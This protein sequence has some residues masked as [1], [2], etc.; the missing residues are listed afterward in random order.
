[1]ART[2]STPALD[3][4]VDALLAAAEHAAHAETMA[5]AR[6]FELAAAWAEAHPA[7]VTEDVV[8]ELGELAMYAD[9]PVTLAGEG[10]P[11]MSE[12]A[13]AEFAA[14]IGVST[15]AGRG[16]I[17]SA[18]ECKYRLPKIWD[19]VLAGEVAVW[20]VRRVT[21]HTHRLPQSAAAQVDRDLASFLHS[22]SFAQIERA[23]TAASAEV[24]DE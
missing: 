14:A 10:A 2:T 3:H 18:L 5:A 1:M 24:D 11:G 20:K 16:L 12:F 15:C 17:G 21:E 7:P 19:R 8:D 9:Q 4:P 22:C 6:K 23:V 13:V